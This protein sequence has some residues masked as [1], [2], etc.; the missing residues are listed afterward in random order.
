[1]VARSEGHWLT[2]A[3]WA[4]AVL[5]NG[6]GRYDRALTAAEQGSEYPGELGVATSSLV[7]LIVSGLRGREPGGVAAVVIAAPSRNPAS[8]R[9]PDSGSASATERRHSAASSSRD[10]ASS[11]PASCVCA[12]MSTV[13]ACDRSVLITAVS[14]SGEGSVV[15]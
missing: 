5:Y 8:S 4:T 1:M 3:A 11:M 2:I 7:E 10:A 12:A 9:W 14:C 6:L 15:G 13:L